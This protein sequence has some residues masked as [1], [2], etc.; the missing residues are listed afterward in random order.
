MTDKTEQP[1]VIKGVVLYVDGGCRPGY[2]DQPNT[3]FGG[4]GIH[5]YEYDVTQVG[6]KPKSKKHGATSVGYLTQP[7][8]D[9]VVNPLQYIDGYG[10]LTSQ[11]TNNTAE[12]HGFKQALNLIKEQGYQEAQLLLDSQYVIKGA[13]E[14]YPRW[15]ANNWRKPDGGTYSNRTLWETIAPVYEQLAENMTLR[16]DWVN[17]HSGNLG[18]DRA[19]YLATKGVFKGRNGAENQS[20]ILFS[21]VAKYRNPQPE[22]HPFLS[23][24]RWYFTAHQ[25]ESLRS[26]DGRYV[27]HCGHHGADDT[28]VGKKIADNIAC[29]LYTKE[30][31]KVLEMIRQTHRRLIPNP[32]HELSMGL[33]STICLPRVWDELEK[34]GSD[35]LSIA[36][37]RLGYTGLS[38]IDD[39]VV[40]KVIRP[41]GLTFNLIDVHNFIH[42]QI[43]KYLANE[44]TITDVTDVF[45]RQEK[46]KKGKLN[47]VLN[48]SQQTKCLRPIVKIKE[49]KV[50]EY[51]CTLTV[52][53]D[54]PPY[55]MLN[56]IAKLHPKVYIATW[57]LS[58]HAFRYAMIFDNGEDLMFWMGKDC[59]MELI[60]K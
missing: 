39:Q 33:L 28:L 45:Y 56:R 29:V 20:S 14:Y 22:L 26:K 41:S 16:I 60:C 4:W 40:T 32:L 37:R 49:A 35:C 18:N 11:E 7:E 25:E 23:R 31:I 55:I 21:S 51:P 52:G 8:P 27:Y 2:P 57:T 10:S 54:C 1:A 36:P 44:L 46:T 48:I 19:D 38:T 17:G 42:T 47:T 5:G 9:L 24:N 3:A 34:E 43:D 12:L 30:E 53:I 15:S 59:N 6:I 50:D 58:P 13:V